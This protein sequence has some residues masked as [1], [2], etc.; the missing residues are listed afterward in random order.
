MD[1]DG[2]KIVQV[3]YS[4]SYLNKLAKNRSTMRLNNQETVNQNNHQFEPVR[5]GTALYVLADGPIVVP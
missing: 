3:C 5:L 4:R 1:D 2:L